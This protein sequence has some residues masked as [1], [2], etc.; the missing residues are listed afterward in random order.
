[1]SVVSWGWG[2]DVV[3][4][5]AAAT[6]A[7]SFPPCWPL[8]RLSGMKARILWHLSLC[9]R[10]MWDCGIGSC[11]LEAG[12]NHAGARET[13]LCHNPSSDRLH[14]TTVTQFTVLALSRALCFF[15]NDLSLYHELPGGQSQSMSIFWSSSIFWLPDFS[16]V[17]CHLVKNQ[18]GFLSSVFCFCF[19][20]DSTTE[21]L[22]Y[23]APV[24]TWE[25]FRFPYTGC[26]HCQVADFTLLH[27]EVSVSVCIWICAT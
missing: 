15:C 18:N 21:S 11:V 6:L 13:R 2:S 7:P 14:F 25:K 5:C 24:P 17:S 22:E 1:M 3:L 10:A 16:W 27:L 20:K 23:W 4:P 8:C 19:C 12:R 26:I 9:V